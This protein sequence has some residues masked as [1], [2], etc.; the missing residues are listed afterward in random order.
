[1][2][3]SASPVAEALHALSAALSEH[4]LRWYVFG[5]QA[6]IVHGSS[7]ATKDVDVTVDSEALSAR[8]LI[9]TLATHGLS[10]REPNAEL[11]AT[12]MRVIPLLHD[13]SGVPVDVVL[14]GP[15]L[16]QLFLARAELHD[17]AG[18]LVPVARAEDVVAMKLLAARP[19]DLED[20]RAIVR[21]RRDLDLDAIRE[22]LALL[23]EALAQ[24]DLVRSLDALLAGLGRRRTPLL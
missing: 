22:T 14:A 4:G 10:A 19:H 5:A 21:A 17:L 9:D 16:E 13:S 24:D 7:R 1:M 15:G 11:L 20:A 6:A 8:A 12:T 2:P 18:A 23:D 3:R